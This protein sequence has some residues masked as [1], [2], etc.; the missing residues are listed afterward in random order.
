MEYLDLNTNHKLPA[1]GFG[2][3]RITPDEAAQQ[4]VATALA[5]GY[6]LIDTAHIYGNERGVGAAI[7]ESGI[8]RADL[9]VTSKLW[10][11]DQGYDRALKAFDQSL[12]KL[13]LEYLDLY[14]IHWPATTKRHESWRALE[15]LYSEGRIK[16][17]GVSNYTRQHLEE[18]RQRSPLT[19]AVNQVEFHAFIYQQQQTV[20]TYCKQQGIVV[21]AYS[22]LNR[23]SRE[24]HGLVLEIAQ[25][26]DKT[27]QQIVL[28]WCVQHGTVPLLRSTNPEHIA[29]NFMVFD[30]ELSDSDI[31]A[32][33]TLSD[34]ERVTWDP[35]GMG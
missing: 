6:R 29:N 33:D 17:A 7:R 8:P 13:G 2:T 20:L 15:R 5:I 1:I 28:R 30:F 21:E 10:N 31:E 35:A 16:A 9:F 27:P 23:L 19:P 11:D 22:P 24:E 25:K 32:L 26:Y 3:W 14:L 12:Q 4:A 18:L 34:G